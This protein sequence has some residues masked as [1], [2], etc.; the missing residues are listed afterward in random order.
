MTVR[1]APGPQISPENRAASLIRDPVHG[2]SQRDGTSEPSVEEPRA[3]FKVCLVGA[4]RG[5]K[6]R[7]LRPH[8]FDP[9]DD[10]Y[11]ATLGTKV[12]KKALQSN[13]FFAGVPLGVDLVIWDITGRREFRELLK[14]AYFR[15]AKGVVAVAD[16]TRRSTLDDLNG[17]IADVED[18]TGR[19]PVV[20]IGANHTRKEQLQ[21]SEE[22]MSRAAQAH[23]AP[24]FFASENADEGVE[25]ALR[26]LADTVL[27]RSL[28]T[29][30]S[31]S[32]R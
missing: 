4:D 18:V 14:E 24:C 21:V 8:V 10:K 15:G 29:R 22:E 26:Y 31:T 30:N 7:L 1:S 11:A 13:I 25:T 2:G 20:V 28:A 12:T 19:I 6:T 17:W 5:C 23:D 16:M 27:R 32:E 9:M 3:K